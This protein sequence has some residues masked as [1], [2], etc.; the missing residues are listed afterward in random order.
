MNSRVACINQSSRTLPHASLWLIFTWLKIATPFSISNLA[1]LKDAMWKRGSACGLNYEIKKRIREHSVLLQAPSYCQSKRM[2]RGRDRDFTL[3]STKSPTKSYYQSAL[4]QISSTSASDD[5]F[6]KW[7]PRD[8]NVTCQKYIALADHIAHVIM[9]NMTTTTDSAD[10]KNSLFSCEEVINWVLYAAKTGNDSVE[11]RKADTTSD[12]HLHYRLLRIQDEW[13][14]GETICNSTHVL[15]PAYRHDPSLL[16]Q[17]TNQNIPDLLPIELLAL[18]SVWYLPISAAPHTIDR[19]DPS[20]GIKPR[21]LTVGDCNTTIHPGDYLRIHFD[22]RRFCETNTWDW[23]CSINETKNGKQGVIVARDDDVGY[24]II[25]KPSNVPVHARVDNVLENVA[26]SVGRMLWMERREGLTLDRS[27]SELS[28]AT[29]NLETSKAN[30]RKQKTDQLVYV[31][32]PQRLDQNTSGLLV[33][34]TE[35]S[36][37]AYFAKL[38]RTKVS[39]SF[40]LMSS[41]RLLHT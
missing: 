5:S 31:A 11:L 13:R 41:Y 15:D 14:E 34:A 10:T 8:A 6:P 1:H 26:S 32:T 29:T 28:D 20:S 39:F 17:H 38:L 30:K 40:G 24:L 37:A 19:F 27:T 33:V 36:F 25:D 21:R 12:L 35:K 3:K 4:A 22:P 2:T 9:P 18:G 7:W 23:G 16:D